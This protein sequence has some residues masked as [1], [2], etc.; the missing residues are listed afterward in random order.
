M[1][2]HFSITREYNARLREYTRD[3]GPHYTEEL[4]RSWLILPLL[5]L[6][7]LHLGGVGFLSTDEP[8]YASIG[9][10]MAQSGDW[11]T[12]HLN[13]VPWFEKSPLVYWMTAAANRAGLRDEWA[14]RLPVALMSVA[15][16][17]FFFITLRREFSTHVATIATAI[18]STSAGWLVY[19]SVEVMDVPMTTALGAALLI[20]VFDT[21]PRRGWLAGAMLGLAIL[22]KGFAPLAFFGPVWLFARGKRVAS[23]AGAVVVAAPWYLLCWF[24]NGSV[25]WNEFFWKHHVARFVS[26][27]SVQHGQPYWYYLPVVLGLLFPWTPLV[28]LLARKETYADVRVRF[29]LLWMAVPLVFFTVAQNKLAGYVLPVLPAL[30][31]VLAV[32]LDQIGKTKAGTTAPAWWLAGCAALMFF[33]PGIAAALPELINLGVR[34]AH[35]TFGPGGLPFVLAAAGVWWLA[36]RGHAL[37]ATLAAALTVAIGVGYLKV[38]TFPV[39]DQRVSARGFWRAHQ[40]EVSHACLD[41]SVGRAWEYGLNYYAGQALPRCVGGQTGWW[42]VERDGALALEAR[43]F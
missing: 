32:G 37:T 8:R 20:T 17:A 19:S 42:I 28:A 41:Y 10:E 25:F 29:V 3:Y 34:K 15:F 35:W 36:F 12:P 11:V 6:Y 16:L 38:R 23:L 1:G 9:R 24:R 30:A 2:L 26:A 22:A 27:D 4:S 43:L 21:R 40:F 13:G 18:L 7:V 5:L 31:I 33:L 39:L 14:A